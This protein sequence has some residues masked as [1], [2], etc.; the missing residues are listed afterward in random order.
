MTAQWIIA[1]NRPIDEE[2]RT[3]ITAVKLQL[4]NLGTYVTTTTSNRKDKI[5]N[6]Q[7]LYPTFLDLMLN[8]GVRRE[9]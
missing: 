4:N 3:Q 7:Y 6:P 5:L 9:L 1:K 8:I 2:N